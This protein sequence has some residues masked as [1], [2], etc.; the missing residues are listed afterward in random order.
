V[1]FEGSFPSLSLSPSLGPS[2]ASP[3]RAPSWRDERS[4]RRKASSWG[5]RF[6]V[7]VT[8]LPTSRR[9]AP[10]GHSGRADRPGAHFDRT[11]LAILGG[12]AGGGQGRC[13]GGQRSLLESPGA[14]TLAL[15]FGV[16]KRTTVS[17]L[18]S[19]YRKFI[20]CDLGMLTNVVITAH[21]YNRKNIHIARPRIHDGSGVGML[22]LKS[23]AITTFGVQWVVPP[24]AAERDALSPSIP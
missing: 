3:A 13:S 9:A 4:L 23:I 15:R 8:S 11:G 17:M 19:N 16:W 2:P 10:T 18:I 7:R 14:V 1:F 24:H 6:L 12:G 5:C 22:T 21:A 20:I